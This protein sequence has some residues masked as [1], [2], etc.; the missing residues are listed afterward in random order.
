MSVYSLCVSSRR[1]QTR[2]AL[3]T[4][5]QTCALPILT[6]PAT[7]WHGASKHCNPGCTHTSN[8][9]TTAFHEIFAERLYVTRKTT[10]TEASR[11]SFPQHS[12]TPTDRK[13]VVQGKSMSV[14]AD[15]GGSGIIKKKRP[16]ERRS[17]SQKL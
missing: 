16:K 11:W 1:R 8:I 9:H 2:C 14:R 7:Y 15:L 12:M 17:E 4:G 3:V 5:V 10:L 6:L 13:S